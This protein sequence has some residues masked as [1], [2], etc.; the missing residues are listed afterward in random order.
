MA[1]SLIIVGKLKQS[2]FLSSVR[3]GTFIPDDVK[4]HP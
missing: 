2:S 3:Y 1:H 4:Q